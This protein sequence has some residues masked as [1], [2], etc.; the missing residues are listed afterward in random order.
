MLSAD[1]PVDARPIAYGGFGYM[2]VGLFKNT[3]FDALPRLKPW[4]SDIIVIV[5]SI[6]DNGQNPEQIY[7]TATDVHDRARALFP[8]AQMMVVKP[9][10]QLE[11]RAVRDKSAAVL[12]AARD[13]HIPTFDPLPEEWFG[14]DRDK[15]AADG[16]HPINTGHTFMAPRTA[17]HM[18]DLIDAQP[19]SDR[20]TMFRPTRQDCR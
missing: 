11:S 18:Q 14:L 9:T 7:S 8:H 3:F 10:W 20:W 15:I 2:I 6:N 4:Q 19:N 17:P 12:L 1:I 16:V 13:V 5:G